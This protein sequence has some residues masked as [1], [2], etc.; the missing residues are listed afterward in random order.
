[1]K[2][3]VREN[4]TE[5]REC[6]RASRDDSNLPDGKEEKGFAG[7]ANDRRKTTEVRK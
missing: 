3:G 2:T 1:M 5:E 4:I 7:R 6:S